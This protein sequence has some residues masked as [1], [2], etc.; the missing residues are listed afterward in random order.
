MPL[1]IPSSEIRTF[2]HRGFIVFSDLIVQNEAEWIKKTIAAKKANLSPLDHKGLSITDFAEL[3]KILRKRGLGQIAAQL[4]SAKTI[5]VS[6]HLYFETWKE[7]EQLEVRRELTPEEEQ[8]RAKHAPRTPLT[9]ILA[10]SLDERWGCYFKKFAPSPKEI[11][12]PTEGNFY[13]LYLSSHPLDE[14]RAPLIYG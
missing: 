14:S 12:L 2:Q 3:K 7:I 11:E 13:L 8:E 9:S 5:R 4:M 6:K 10:L 1:E